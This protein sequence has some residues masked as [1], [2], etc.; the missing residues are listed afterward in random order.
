M[1]EPLPT[2]GKGGLPLPSG[3]L[4]PQPQQFTPQ[5]VEDLNAVVPQGAPELKTQ[6][7]A[8]ACHGILAPAYMLSCFHEPRVPLA[9][10]S[11]WHRTW[12]GRRPA[13]ASAKAKKS[14]L[15]MP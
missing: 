11:L 15:Q 6:H 12:S 10:V 4:P 9:F 13:H 8:Q 3:G 14:S 2:P 1:R 5:S 7:P